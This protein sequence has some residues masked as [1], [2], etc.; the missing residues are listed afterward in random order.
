MAKEIERKFLVFYKHTFL[1][2]LQASEIVQ[3]YLH[4][5][6]MTSRIRLIDGQQAVLTL[7]GPR[8]GISRDEFEYPIPYADGLAL[9]AYCGDHKLEKLRYEVL[10]SNHIWHVDVYLGSLEGLVTAEIELSVENEKFVRPHWL[11][12]E[13]TK[14]RGY[15]NKSL[16]K[17][18]RVPLL[19]VA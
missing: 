19:Q 3:G 12:P 16:A 4:D 17:A 6:G 9:L 7:K 11:G 10:V 13:V 14:V 15:S 5:K 1:G 8:S 2:G 18:S